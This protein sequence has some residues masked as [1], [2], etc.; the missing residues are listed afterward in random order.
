MAN[1]ANQEARLKALSV[2]HRE[3]ETEAAVLRDEHERQYERGNARGAL[4]AGLAAGEARNNAK[5]LQRIGANSGYDQ[6][7]ASGTQMMVNTALA[8]LQPAAGA[9]G[10]ALVVHTA[11]A[12]SGTQP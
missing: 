7:A 8:V 9:V 11:G 1:V 12:L 4:A 10:H 6:S 5:N 2:V 3:E